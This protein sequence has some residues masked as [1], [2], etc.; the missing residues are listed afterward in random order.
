MRWLINEGLYNPNF[1]ICSSAKPK[2]VECCDSKM[3]YDDSGFVKDFFILSAEGQQN[4]TLRDGC[5]D[6][7]VYVK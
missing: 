7:C 5:P 1:F 2:P 6:R 4:D 3:E